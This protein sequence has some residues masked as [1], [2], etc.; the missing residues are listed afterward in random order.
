VRALPHGPVRRSGRIACRAVTKATR[1]LSWFRTAPGAGRGAGK[2]LEQDIGI[3]RRPVVDTAWPPPPRRGPGRS[4]PDDG[5]PAGRRLPAK[6]SPRNS[7][8]WRASRRACGHLPR[9]PRAC[10]PGWRKQIA[11]THQNSR[12]CGPGRCYLSCMISPNQGN[13]PGFRVQVP[14]D[15]IFVYS[16]H[17]RAYGNF[18]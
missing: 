2:P 16:S 17:F 18:A 15:T 1:S 14:S 8:W 9:Q 13:L 5:Q 12:A 7:A 3:R 10:G 4:V 11:N 6:P